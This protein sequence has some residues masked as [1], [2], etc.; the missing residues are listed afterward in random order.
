L[1]DGTGLTGPSLLEGRYRLDRLSLL[2]DFAATISRAGQN[3]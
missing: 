1:K 3:F 2:Q